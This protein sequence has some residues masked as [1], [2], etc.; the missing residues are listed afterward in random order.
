MMNLIYKENNFLGWI[1]FGDNATPSPIGKIK[2]STNY[3]FRQNLLN[4]Q[5][6]IV[7]FCNQNK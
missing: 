6:L 1:K 4:S 3:I 2:N 7:K 5:K